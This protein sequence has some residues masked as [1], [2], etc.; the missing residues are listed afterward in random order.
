[1]QSRQ[2]AF[3]NGC[4]LVFFIFIIQLK[5]L[6]DR[7][8]KELVQGHNVKKSRKI[9]MQV[10]RHYKSWCQSCS[11]VC[12]SEYSTGKLWEV[13]KSKPLVLHLKKVGLLIYSWSL[14]YCV[15]QNWDKT[16][17]TASILC[18]KFQKEMKSYSLAVKKYWPI[19]YQLASGFW[20][21]L[22]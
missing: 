5:N 14:S 7:E 22:W 6:N 1:M 18:L 15:W 19:F 9:K 20:A 4:R 11:S 16:W 10:Y 12:L 21:L 17:Y 3:W 8:V 2:D 13:I